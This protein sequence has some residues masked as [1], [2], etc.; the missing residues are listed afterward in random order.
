MSTE[1]LNRL[2]DGLLTQLP[3]DLVTAAI[4]GG[5]TAVI[6]LLKRRKDRRKR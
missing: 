1:I 5:V 3:A 6:G 4:V 2:L